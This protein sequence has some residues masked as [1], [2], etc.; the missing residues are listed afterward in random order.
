MENRDGGIGELKDNACQCFAD[1]PLI[2]KI[3]FKRQI[4]DTT[5]QRKINRSGR[6]RKWKIRL[7]NISAREF[8]QTVVRT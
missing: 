3:S 1:V 8:I 2:M 5:N 7:Y 4:S 6:M